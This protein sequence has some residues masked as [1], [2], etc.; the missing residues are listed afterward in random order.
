MSSSLQR[1]R[2]REGKRLRRRGIAKWQ[3]KEEM[4]IPSER[5]R[6][7]YCF[8]SVFL[9]FTELWNFAMRW[10]LLQWLSP[11]EQKNPIS[12]IYKAKKIEKKLRKISSEKKYEI[13]ALREKT[14]LKKRKE[15]KEIWER[16]DIERQMWRGGRAEKRH[17]WQKRKIEKN[18][19]KLIVKYEIVLQRGRYW[20]KM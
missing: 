9:P 19:G 20:V 17:G 16:R 4:E 15:K 6:S 10:Q 11:G 14:P 1:E 7:H 18:M 12:S 13:E 2:E 8:L 5:D 3:T